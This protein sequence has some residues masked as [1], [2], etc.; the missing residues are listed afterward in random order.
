MTDYDVIINQGAERIA[1]IEAVIKDQE[2]FDKLSADD[3]VN[4]FKDYLFLKARL[5][6]WFDEAKE[7]SVYEEIETGEES[8]DEVLYTVADSI[9]IGEFCLDELNSPFMMESIIGDSGKSIENVNSLRDEYINKIEEK[10]PEE[11]HDKYKS[12]KSSLSAD[13]LKFNNKNLSKLSGELE[14]SEKEI[15]GSFRRMAEQK[16][17][18]DVIASGA[19]ASKFAQELDQIE[20]AALE[21]IRSEQE[22][23]ELF[24]E[25]VIVEEK[26]RE[27]EQNRSVFLDAYKK[28]NPNM[29]AEPKKEDDIT[30]KMLFDLEYDLENYTSPIGQE[31][32]E[33]GEKVE[34]QGQPESGEQIEGQEQNKYN[35]DEIYGNVDFNIPEVNEENV[36]DI[37]VDDLNSDELFPGSSVENVQPEEEKN[38]EEEQVV[39][40]DQP[41]EEKNVEEEQVEV[42][43]QSEEEKNIEENQLEENNIELNDQVEEE[44]NVEGLDQVDEKNQIEENDQNLEN[45]QENIIN[46]NAVDDVEKDSASVDGDAKNIIVNDVIQLNKDENK[47]INEEPEIDLKKVLNDLDKDDI[48]IQNDIFRNKDNEKLAENAQDAVDLIDN[49]DNDVANQTE[50]IDDNNWAYEELD[51][52]ER[53]LENQ[54]KFDA[55]EDKLSMAKSYILSKA[56][57]HPKY[58]HTVKDE[59]MENLN[60]NKMKGTLNELLNHVKSADNVKKELDGTHI[61]NILYGDVFCFKMQV[62]ENPDPYDEKSYSTKIR[63]IERTEQYNLNKYGTYDGKPKPKEIKIIESEF[64]NDINELFPE[65]ENN[66]EIKQKEEEERKERIRQRKKADADRRLKEKK[67]KEERDKSIEESGF[68]EEMI[69]SMAVTQGISSSKDRFNRKRMTEKEAEVQMAKIKNLFCTPEKYAEIDVLNKRKYMREYLY[70]F[71]VKNR[72][73]YNF[74]F[75]DNSPQ[76]IEGMHDQ[77]EKSI[78]HNS[79]VDEK[80]AK[81]SNVKDGKEAFKILTESETIKKIVSDHIDE[82]FRNLNELFTDKKDDVTPKVDAYFERIERENEIRKNPKKGGKNLDTYIIIHTGPKASSSKEDMLDNLSKVSAAI[83]M[84]NAGAKFDLK[85]LHEISERYYTRFPKLLIEKHADFEKNLNYALTSTDAVQDFCKNM[86][87]ALFKV[88][89]KKFNDYQND[90]KKIL[91]NMSSP[92]GRTQ[93]YQNFYNSVKAITEIKFEEGLQGEKKDQLVQKIINANENLYDATHAY[94]QGKEKVRRQNY[95]K[96]SFDNALDV[97]STVTKYMPSTKVC[98]MKIVDKINGIRK[99][100]SLIDKEKFLSTYS[101][102]RAAEAN[103]KKKKKDNAKVKEDKKMV[104]GM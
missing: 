36:S 12:V 3:K 31:Q 76:F 67:E 94:I 54:E 45:N 11:F 34:D 69:D 102:N 84:K 75:E 93:K 56:F 33:S 103:S 9:K 73:E 37:N 88:N 32:P 70:A 49:I 18:D 16:D 62:I 53:I 46:I 35:Y 21:E 1:D 77:L 5:N 59:I 83:K 27:K 81:I 13:S 19:D 98:T 80:V 38:V 87:T 60:S 65:N 96:K 44:N 90:M 15:N 23:E 74:K 25:N 100:D 51:R 79:Q 61:S 78:F 82:E 10:V 6:P 2:K 86:Q 47:V 8:L 43:N 20:D 85:E 30:D 29:K 4:M 91:D 22:L 39:D 92:K 63:G 48:Q 55:V 66:N 95:G 28:N 71:G 58:M 26:R 97:L 50:E 57:L 52:T 7:E 89:L 40:N 17:M 41:E 101:A 99:K 68:K 104:K 14:E 24:P 42:S 64:D 72:I